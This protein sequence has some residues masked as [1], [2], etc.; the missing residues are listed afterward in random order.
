VIPRAVGRRTILGVA[1]APG[2]G[3]STLAATLAEAHGGFVVPMDGFHL[4]DDRLRELGLHGRKGAPETFDA[5]G[6]VDLLH[7]LRTDPAEVRAPAFDRAR[8][9]T[10]P[11]SIAVPPGALVITEGNYLLLDVP[12]WDQVRALLD[13]CWFVR[14]PEPRRI[15]RLVARHVGFGWDPVV[16][17][18]RATTGSDGDNA[19]LVAASI[20]RADRVVDCG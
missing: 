15:A 16:A 9:V 20:V 7:R 18:A 19:R 4:S 5:Q 10:V 3:K 1:G 13:E 17:Q 11:E 14:T 12:P 8:E 6:Y 2:A